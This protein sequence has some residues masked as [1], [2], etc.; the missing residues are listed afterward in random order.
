MTMTADQSRR[1]RCRDGCEPWC[2]CSPSLTLAGAASRRRRA[3]RRRDQEEIDEELGFEKF[4][5]TCDTQ[6]GGHPDVFID[7]EFATRRGAFERAEQLPAV[8]RIGVDT[9]DRLHRQPAR[10]CRNA[11]WRSSASH[12]PGRLAGRHFGVP[13]LRLRYL[14][15]ALQHGDRPDQAGLLASRAADRLPV[16][17]ELRARTDS[18]YG[19]D[20]IISD[21]SLSLASTRSSEPLGSARPT[22]STTCTV[23]R[24]RSQASAPAMRLRRIGCP[25][26]D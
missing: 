12:L 23:H 2:C 26:A 20:A 14:L 11:R 3:R 10:R 7:A 24:R 6:A 25:P 21:T 19:L 17:L 22:R 1:S 15:P 18:D 9:A 16:F 13:S 8:R 5:V 4:E